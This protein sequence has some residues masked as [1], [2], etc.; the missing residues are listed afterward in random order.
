M[1]PPKGHEPYAGC[2]KGGRPKTKWTDEEI[3]KEADAFWEWLQRP[4]SIWFESFCIERG[5]PPDYIARWAKV[6]DKFDRVY[7]FAQGWQK[8][9]LIEGG[10]TSKFNSGF[11]KF[12]MSNTCGWTE[13]QHLTGDSNN[14]LAFV[15]NS[16]D[17]NSKELVYG[18]DSDSN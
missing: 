15:L 14:P 17:G 16:V 18:P 11:C 3:E 9:K 6:N 13:K 4:E 1:A 8:N 5:Y 2:E 7:T 12:V 10:L